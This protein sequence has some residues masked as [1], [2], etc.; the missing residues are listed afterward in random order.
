MIWRERIDARI[1]GKSR[2]NPEHLVAQIRR[3]FLK[4]RKTA[5]FGTM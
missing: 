3:K 1:R 5:K 2:M 4:K